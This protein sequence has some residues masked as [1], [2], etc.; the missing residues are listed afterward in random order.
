MDELE[1][2][3]RHRLK[4]VVKQISEQ[5]RQLVPLR[6]ELRRALEDGG[7]SGEALAR[8]DHYRGAIEAHFEL[9]V[10]VFF[11]A[12]HGL[13]PEW[14]RELGALEGEH[15]GL[16]QQL[17]AL[18]AGLEDGDGGD[19]RRA[20]EAFVAQLGEHEGREERLVSRLA[21]PAPGG[22]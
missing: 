3:L 17:E 22:S 10:E 8:L 19:P 4:R 2:G 9:E 12:I 18:R 5:H 21:G 6:E 16:R 20:L 15:V 7:A 1:T 14:S 11:P 13:H